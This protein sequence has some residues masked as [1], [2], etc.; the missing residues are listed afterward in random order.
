MD[1]TNFYTDRHDP[2]AEKTRAF[3][4]L[5]PQDLTEDII[6]TIQWR[7]TALVDDIYG[8]SVGSDPP[9][10]L[11][12]L[13]RAFIKD[14]YFKSII[15]GWGTIVLAELRKPSWNN[16]DYERI[17]KDAYSL[18]DAMAA[19]IVRNIE[20]QDVV[21]LTDPDGT[22]AWSNIGSRIVD[23]ARRTVNWLGQILQTD[24]ELD[25]TNAFDTDVLY[26]WSRLG[27][28]VYALEKRTSLMKGQAMIQ[29]SMQTFQTGDVEDGDPE[30]E[31]GSILGLLSLRNLPKMF[32]GGSRV[33]EMGMKSNLKRLQNLLARAGYSVDINGKLHSSGMIQDQRLRSTFE[34]LFSGRPSRN[35][36]E[37]AASVHAPGLLT[38]MLKRSKGDLENS[39]DVRLPSEVIS[40]VANEYG[41]N[42]VESWLS[43]DLD[44]I[45]AHALAEGSGDLDMGDPDMETRI[46]E[47]VSGDIA[48]VV[49]EM[50]PE[51]GGIFSRWAVNRAKKRYLKR[52]RRAMAKGGRVNVRERQRRDAAQFRNRRREESGSKYMQDFSDLGSE[53]PSD[54]QSEMTA[55]SQEDQVPDLSMFDSPGQS[56]E[57][58]NESE[59]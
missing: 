26:E 38:R 1:N 35:L 31:V 3:L 34:N 55:S 50:S 2:G 33:Q 14:E 59:S 25:Q 54:E 21:S 18:P 20:T 39:G 53:Q 32:K 16:D 15:L 37:G 5:L 28:A 6:R 17:L 42:I 27:D 9:R 57:Q 58:Y 51:A 24:W 4:A 41:D 11:S 46:M 43:G 48:P 49:S 12:F 22:I 40:N 45:V 30:F 36:I 56:S 23:T 7:G 47:S 10:S 52:K 13:S 44:S 8:R 29:T 19:G